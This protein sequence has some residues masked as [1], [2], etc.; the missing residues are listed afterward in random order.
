MRLLFPIRLALLVCL[1]VFCN[2][3]A[4]CVQAEVM[5]RVLAGSVLGALIGWS[6]TE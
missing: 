5:T 4:W 2:M 1:M 3:V 6:W